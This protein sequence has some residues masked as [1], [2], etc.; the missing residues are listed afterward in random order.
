[1]DRFENEHCG[2]CVFQD[3]DLKQYLDNCGNLMSMH[4]VK[5]RQAHEK[6]SAATASAVEHSLYVRE[7]LVFVYICAKT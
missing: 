6:A 3:S 7:G 1:M 4:N 2:C 5:V